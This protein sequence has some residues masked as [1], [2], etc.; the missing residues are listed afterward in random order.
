MEDFKDDEK[1]IHDNEANSVIRNHL[2]WAMGAGFIPVP[3]ADFFAV[4]AI[5]LDMVRPVSYTHLDVYKRQAKDLPWPHHPAHVGHPINHVWSRYAIATRP[6]PVDICPERHILRRFDGESAMGVD[7]S[8][9][10]I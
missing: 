9:I 1:N 8:L 4:G 2:V 3:V 7:L 5:Q 10:H 6:Q